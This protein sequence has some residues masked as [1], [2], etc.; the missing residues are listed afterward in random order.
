MLNTINEKP[1]FEQALEKILD[2][3]KSGNRRTTN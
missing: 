1:F 2:S 3:L